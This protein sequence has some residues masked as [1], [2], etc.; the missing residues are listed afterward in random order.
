MVRPDHHGLTL[1][2]SAFRPFILCAMTLFGC[3][4]RFVLI[5]VAA[6]RRVEPAPA[7]ATHVAGGAVYIAHRGA[8]AYAPKD[9]LPAYTLAM[10][11]GADYVEQ[12]G[13]R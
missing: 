4:P 10:E 5:I 6:T 3:G 9:T 7:V 2:T 12:D 8:S 11:M 13:G 1:L